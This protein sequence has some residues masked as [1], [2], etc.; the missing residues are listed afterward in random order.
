MLIGGCKH[1]YTVQSYRMQSRT[2]TYSHKGCG[3]NKRFGKNLR[4]YTQKESDI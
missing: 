2:L 3:D 1:V 4:E